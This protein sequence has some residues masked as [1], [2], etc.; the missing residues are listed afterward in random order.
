[1]FRK[2]VFILPIILTFFICS[3]TL[4]QTLAVMGDSLSDEY[5]EE[6]YDYAL[7]WVEQLVFYRGVDV[8]PTAE[9]AGQFGG[10]WGEPRRTGYQ[11]NW[12][13]WGATSS[14]L[15][16]QGQHIG[17]ANQVD[18]FNIS[19]GVLEI[20]AN[21]FDPER[22]PYYNIYYG[23]WSNFQIEN[24][25]DQSLA[26]IEQALVTVYP[27]GINL[28]I[29]N[30]PDYGVVPFTQ[31]FYPNPF[32]RERVTTVIK[33]LNRRIE[34]LARE[35][36]LVLFDLFGLSNSI[37]GSN[38]EPKTMLLIGNVSINLL[39][40]D[41]IN[42]TNPTAGFVHDQIHPHTHLQGIMANVILKGLNVGYNAD[43]SEFSEKK[44]LTHA[45]I[46]YGGEDTLLSEIGEYSEYV[47]NFKKLGDLNSDGMVGVI[48]LLQL[49]AAWGSC[50]SELQSCREDLTGNHNIND[51]DLIILLDNWGI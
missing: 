31:Q 42:N 37:F 33:T 51:E 44:I 27:T 41:T 19:Y 20:G 8:G 12:A 29:T 22:P 18:S 30:V 6:T 43:I 38:F 47:V 32:Y 50:E 7:N 36:N 26:N 4:A 11:F 40:H 28:V 17:L 14:D 46:S 34:D 3:I 24:Y 9:E 5:E 49:L 13:R 45:G 16:N 21:D 23:L 10:T 25:I 1:M 2:A 35:Y 15:L 39:A 48:D